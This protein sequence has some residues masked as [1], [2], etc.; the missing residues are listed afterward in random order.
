MGFSCCSV[1]LFSQ[2]VWEEVKDTENP[3]LQQLAGKLPQTVMH[4]RA[5]STVRKYLSVYKRWKIWAL[6][7]S[8]PVVPTKEHHVGLYLQHLADTVA[9]KSAVDGACN[10]LAWV[11]CTAGFSS[12]MASPLVRAILD[13]L[14]RSLAK[15]TNK[16]APM[17][18]EIL[19][20]MARDTDKSC[21]LSDLRLVTA[22]LLAF[23]GF[24]RFNELVKI[25]SCEISVQGDYMMLH[26]PS[27][28]TD[29][30]RK[31][32]KIVIARTG[33]ATYPVGKLEEYMAKT[34]VAWGEEWFLFRPIYKTKSGG[35][36][37]ETSS[38]SYTLAF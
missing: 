4:S 2:G 35:K 9:S 31:G 30:L 34:H 21:T 10:S 3:E 37:R 28:N 17:I 5:D 25:W 18:I 24:L 19:Q 29:Q 38:I 23:A 12:P 7:H 32:D 13:S 14:R 15:P 20:R 16:K 8:L 1:E 11:H 6:E 26:L 36:L 33:A 22:C 27:S